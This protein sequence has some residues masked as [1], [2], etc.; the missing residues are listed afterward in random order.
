MTVSVSL[1]NFGPIVTGL[2]SC[3]CDALETAG[4]PV[5]RCDLATIGAPAWDACD[6]ACTGGGSGQLAA[7]VGGA[8]M[9]S[10]SFPNP[11]AGGDRQ[12]DTN[13][14]PP[15]LVAPISI[16][17]AR[18]L[19]D[20]QPPTVAEQMA[21]ALAWHDDAT[22]IRQAVGCCLVD[23]KAAR[24]ISRFLIG[25]TRV[26]PPQ[27]GCAGSVLTVEVALAHCVCP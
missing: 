25:A 8:I 27:G 17:I 9:P 7:Y 1:T 16:E 10:L 2:A 11:Y 21:A 4:V 23:M 6:C 24:Q 14:G 5:C 22:L 18:C 13:C 3:V 20:G 12:A 26:L 15:Y 19:P